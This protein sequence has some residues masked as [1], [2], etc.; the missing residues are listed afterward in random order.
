MAV[1][2]F[3]AQTLFPIIE[4]PSVCRKVVCDIGGYAKVRDAVEGT[5]ANIVF[6]RRNV[7]VLAFGA[8]DQVRTAFEAH[9]IREFSLHSIE[10]RRLRYESAELGLLYDALLRAI[11]NER[12]VT[13]SQR[14]RKF[15]TVDPD[16]ASNIAYRE[17]KS[18]VGQ[19]SG[20]VGTTSVGWREATR[21]HLG[22]SDGPVVDS[23]R[24]HNS[25]G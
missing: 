23:D 25:F 1:G 17:L 6:G 2:Q 18:A 4:S 3:F 10:T 15:V 9:N 14:R 24:T 16:Q 20:Q 5:N 21:V 22:I 11:E 13:V 19:I 7:G 8:D 12:P